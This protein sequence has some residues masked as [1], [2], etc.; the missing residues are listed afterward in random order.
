MASP[1]GDPPGRGSGIDAFK[2]VIIGWIRK[3]I[4]DAARAGIGIA[5]QKIYF[6]ATNFALAV[7][8]G[9]LATSTITVPDG[10][11]S[12]VIDV[13]TRVI[14]FNPNVTGGTNGA[15]AD[16][17]AAQAVIGPDPGVFMY[18]STG[19]GNGS[20]INVAPFSDILSGLNPGDT[21]TLAIN[22]WSG[23]LAWAANVDNTAEM[24]GTI[25][26]YR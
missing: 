12:A 13:K 22:A 2:A 16:Y 19:G 5:P 10:M 15:G 23:Y 4:R 6:S 1:V 18:L 3:E 21:F 8:S 14:A 24:S 20:N 7:G 17:F 11:T 25:A 26:W 9:T